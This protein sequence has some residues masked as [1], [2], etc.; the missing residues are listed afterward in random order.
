MLNRMFG[1]L[2]V[3]LAA[4]LLLA[5]ASD[6]RAAEESVPRISSDELKS[7]LG[8]SG[9]VVLDARQLNEWIDAVQKIAGAQRV[10]A[11][12]FASWADNYAKD[13]VLVVYCS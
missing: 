11:Q 8:E 9:L 10:D 1:L 13:Q 6:I 7:R 12:D 3:S 5:T 2:A 4:A